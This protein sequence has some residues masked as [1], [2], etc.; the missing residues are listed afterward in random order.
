MVS[1]V[2]PGIISTIF[3]GFCQSKQLDLIDR[4]NHDMLY[5]ILAVVHLENNLAI[6]VLGELFTFIFLI[7]YLLLLGGQVQLQS[8]FFLSVSSPTRPEIIWL[9]SIITI[10]STDQ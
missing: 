10:T 9:Q 4:L 6:V 2:A 1:L 8:V 7:Y 5:R 3:L